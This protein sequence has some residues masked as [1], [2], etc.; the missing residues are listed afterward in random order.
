[1]KGY[2]RHTHVQHVHVVGYHYSW[3]CIH[4]TCRGQEIMTS[5]YSIFGHRNQ[6]ADNKSVV[7][8]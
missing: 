1:M 6:T 8:V 2:I 3:L 5:Q 7:D 4:L